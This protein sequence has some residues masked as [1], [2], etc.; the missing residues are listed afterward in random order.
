MRRHETQHMCSE[1]IGRVFCTFCSWSLLDCLPL[2]LFLGQGPGRAPGGS[3]GRARTVMAL[4]GLARIFTL[5]ALK[6]RP[7]VRIH[8]GIIR[9]TRAGGLR[10][11]RLQARHVTY[12]RRAEHCDWLTPENGP[13]KKSWGIELPANTFW[14]TFIMLT[15]PCAANYNREPQHRATAATGKHR[16]AFFLC[17]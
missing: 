11:C 6:V 7:G 4:L 1:R 13:L 12:V 3:L 2:G 14:H 16:T 10:L 15:S 17:Q 9:P 5:C 8:F